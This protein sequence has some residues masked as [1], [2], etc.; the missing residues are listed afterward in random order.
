MLCQQGRTP[1]PDQQGRVNPSRLGIS[2][3][4]VVML[5]DQ[6]TKLYLLYPYDLPVREPVRLA[7][8]LDLM[9][10]W[11]R[12]ISYGLFQQDGD[13]GRW[14]LVGVSLIAALALGAW[15]TKARSLVLALSL[16]LVAG[17]AVGNAIDRIAHGAVFD[18]IHI[19]AMSFSWY[20]FNVAD[21]AIVAGVVGLL[22]DS[23]VLEGRRAKK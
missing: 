4:V 14:L 23:F 11:N 21:A 19:H 7:P 15:I 17:G 3:A 1:S 10:V 8:F 22:Y 9:V 13:L 6:V 12:G 16:G 2:T 5:V 18:F 20:V